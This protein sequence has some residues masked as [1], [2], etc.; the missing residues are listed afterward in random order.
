MDQV[1]FEPAHY[2][3]AT[4]LKGDGHHS[5]KDSSTRFVL[6][7]SFWSEAFKNSTNTKFW[8]LYSFNYFGSSSVSTFYYYCY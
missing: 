1:D 6:Y 7:Y 2:Y 4:I 8:L 3:S 5:E